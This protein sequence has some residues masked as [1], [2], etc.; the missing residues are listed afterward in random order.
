MRIAAC[1]VTLPI[2]LA[3][4]AASQETEEALGA[5][6]AFDTL[7]E[8]RVPV[9]AGSVL[10]ELPDPRAPAL[11]TVDAGTELPLLERRGGWVRV[12]YGALKGWVLEEGSAGDSGGLPGP[13]P[14]RSP[15]PELLSRARFHLNGPG[16]PGRLGPFA[17]Y[18][19]LD[20]PDFLGF[21]ERVVEDLLRVYRERFG[22]EVG[23]DLGLGGDLDPDAPEGGREALVLFSR[24]DGYR[25]FAE[26]DVALAGLEEGGFAGFGL[27]ALYA[28]SR[29]RQEVASLL[30]HEVTHLLNARALG[31]RTPPW[32]EEGLADSLAYSRIDA[33]GRLQPEELGGAV[34]EQRAEVRDG[35]GRR[36]GWEVTVTTRGG[37]GALQRLAEALDRGDLPPP[38][39]LTSL[40]WRELVEP[41]AR[42]VA[43]AESAFFV[44]WLLAGEG[45]AAGFREYLR[46]VAAGG[47]GEGSDLLRALGEDWQDLDRGFRR[48]LRERALLSR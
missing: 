27:A 3:L 44:R 23:L 48:W 38:S 19:D 28:G 31:P 18:T 4:P 15:D 36:A 7:G 8:E 22:L 9:A 11:A 34:R 24:E 5:P 13:L 37:R 32:L 42:E 21:L 46:S 14:G 47:A 26:G 10:R 17:F 41:R 30:V 33:S 35:R 16:A 40:G 45:R 1:V 39:T 2:L 12:R 20:D 6:A 29:G 25:A 43:Y